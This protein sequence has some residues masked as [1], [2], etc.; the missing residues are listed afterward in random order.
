MRRY[1]IRA[2]FV[3]FVPGELEER[4]LYVSIEY[5]TSVHL[6]ACGCGN[7]VVTPIN[8]AEWQLIYDGESVSLYP[9]IGNWQFPC[10][11]HYWV[12]RNEIHW[13]RPW[14]EG[15][16]ESGRERDAADLA[17]YYARREERGAEASTSTPSGNSVV[18][19]LKR[20]LRLGG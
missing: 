19:R 11:S 13:A 8:P 7:K 15:E 18:T 9:S 12:R 16:I 20:L 5:A 3:D 10:R 4:K 1:E 17:H 6:C 14:S 2:E